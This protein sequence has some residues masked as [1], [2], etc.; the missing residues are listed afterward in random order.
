M[1]SSRL[2]LRAR[3]VLSVKVVT[4]P[5]TVVPLL[6]SRPSFRA[7]GLP[8]ASFFATSQ[9][10]PGA[11]GSAAAFGDNIPRPEKQL[12][13]SVQ[14]A[15]AAQQGRLKEQL[16]GALSVVLPGTLFNLQL[17]RGLEGET[18]ADWICCIKR[19]IHPSSSITVS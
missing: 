7:R 16:H 5:T 19:D 17:L 3:E 14:T 11:R 10:R 18:V 12:S 9:S 1:S 15:Q 8:W 2:G 13:P 4:G 6:S